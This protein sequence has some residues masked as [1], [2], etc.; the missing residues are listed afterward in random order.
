MRI[1]QLILY[2]FRAF[3]SCQPFNFADNVTV[4]AGV[5]GR[6]KTAL[7]DALAFLIS[8]LLPQISPALSFGRSLKHAV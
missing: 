3:E 5:N 6:G 4:V 2:N 1:R 7:L 8:R